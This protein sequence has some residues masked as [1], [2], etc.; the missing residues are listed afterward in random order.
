MGIVGN[1]ADSLG[2]FLLTPIEELSWRW[3]DGTA[4]AF[5]ECRRCSD[6]RSKK[7]SSELARKRLGPAF[8]SGSTSGSPIVCSS[9]GVEQKKGF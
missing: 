7:G 9:L 8:D 3:I 1:E 4:V 2:T 6:G 5:S